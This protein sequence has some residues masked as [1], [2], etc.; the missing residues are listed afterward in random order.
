MR[1]FGVGLGMLGEQ[2][3]EGI[4]AEFDLLSSTFRSVVL[5]LDRLEMIVKQHCLTTLPQQ[6]AKVPEPCH[7]KKK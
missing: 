6:I 4:H 3:G 7:R 2:N 5:E 1:R